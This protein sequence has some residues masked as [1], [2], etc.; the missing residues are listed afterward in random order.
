MR[1]SKAV[2]E[3]TNIEAEI[4]QASEQLV[5]LEVLFVQQD[6]C[7]ACEKL[8]IH[9]LGKYLQPFI[10]V[11]DDV[12]INR[13]FIFTDITVLVLKSLVPLYCSGSQ[14]IRFQ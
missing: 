14:E 3:R 1:H 10:I 12:T 9:P 13:S 2:M 8:L 7:I 5:G 4:R 6:F 11:T